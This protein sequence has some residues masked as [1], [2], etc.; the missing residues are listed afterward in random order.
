[1]ACQ[2]SFQAV[3]D[4]RRAGEQGVGLDCD[5]LIANKACSAAG[6][7]NGYK[8]CVLSC[9]GDVVLYPYLCNIVL[10]ENVPPKQEFNVEPHR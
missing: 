6:S 7:G 10:L 8:R 3:T 2:G 5:R 9:C 4:S 1:M